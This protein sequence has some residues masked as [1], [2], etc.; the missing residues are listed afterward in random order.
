MAWPDRRFTDLFKI[1]HPICVAPMA[2]AMD[3]ELAAEVAEAGGLG[4]MP[5]AMLDARSGAGRSSRNTARAPRK[6]IN[7]G[8]FC[9]TPPELNNAREAAWRERLAPYYREWGIDPSAPVPTTIA[10]RSMRHSA[11]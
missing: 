6:P 5:C 10:G 11:I 1:E 4:S 7:L 9:H 3:H 8:F 2:G